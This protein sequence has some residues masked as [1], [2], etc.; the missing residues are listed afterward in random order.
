M[1]RWAVPMTRWAIPMTRWTIPS[2]AAAMIAT[3][4]AACGD[5]APAPEAHA[6]VRDSAGVRIVEAVVLLDLERG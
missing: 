4:L 2:T 3:A 6:E 5:S 1:T